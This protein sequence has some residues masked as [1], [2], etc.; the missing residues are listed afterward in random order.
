MRIQQPETT[1]ILDMECL[2]RTRAAKE[3]S[4]ALST[5][6]V[7]LRKSR[8]GRAKVPLRYIQIRPHAYVWIPRPWLMKWIEDVAEYGCAI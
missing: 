4:M 7:I 5:L 8:M 1:T 3:L 2:S 6:D